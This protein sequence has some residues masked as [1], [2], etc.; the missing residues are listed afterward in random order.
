MNNYIGNYPANMRCT[1]LA[2]NIREK[3]RICKK[4][5][6]ILPGVKINEIW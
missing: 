1:N 6:N 5:I 2:R 4:F 3:A